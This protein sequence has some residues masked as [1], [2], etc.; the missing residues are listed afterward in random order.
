M[1]PTK[2]TFYVTLRDRLAAVDPQRTA[3][4]DG[5]LRTAIAVSENEPSAPPQCDVFYLRFGGARPLAPATG[6]LMALECVVSYCSSGSSD[7][8]G[9]DR[10]RDLAALDSDLLAMCSPAQSPK[11]D[12][13]VAPPVALGSNI[14]WTPPQM[15]VAK[16]LSHYV[17]RDATIT[18]MFYPE[19]NQL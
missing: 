1:Q 8:G 15:G 14:F 18:I 17:G 12:Y 5:V 7:F 2:D 9:L 19:V 6:T 13:S 10:G 3:T 11:C 16:T 4:L